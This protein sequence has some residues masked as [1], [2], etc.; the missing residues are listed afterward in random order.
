MVKLDS[1]AIT[2]WSHF[3]ASDI[4][5][6]QTSSSAVIIRQDLL[7]LRNE[8]NSCGNFS[9]FVSCKQEQDHTDT[10]SQK[11]LFVY[12]SVFFLQK[13][14]LEA[15]IPKAFWTSVFYMGWVPFNHH[16]TREVFYLLKKTAEFKWTKWININ[17]NWILYQHKQTKDEAY[18][19]S[20]KITIINHQTERCKPVFGSDFGLTRSSLLWKLLYHTAASAAN[21]MIVVEASNISL[22]AA[23]QD[24]DTCKLC[25]SFISGRIDGRHKRSLQLTPQAL[26]YKTTAKTPGWCRTNYNWSLSKNTGNSAKPTVHF[27]SSAEQVL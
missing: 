21:M 23:C 27:Y 22:P 7:F 25:Y 9:S 12:F 1:F 15:H 13:W 14:F 3:Q 20:T 18:V 8:G 16:Q 17:R 11:H 4:F 2:S 24:C 6:E 10:L 19:Q 26:R 5:L